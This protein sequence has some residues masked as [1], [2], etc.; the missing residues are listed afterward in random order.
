MIKLFLNKLKNTYI[1]INKV[2]NIKTKQK[3]EIAAVNYF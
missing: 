2:D 3:K 1:Q